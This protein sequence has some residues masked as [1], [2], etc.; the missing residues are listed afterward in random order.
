[1]TITVPA[2]ARGLRADVFLAREI[3]ASRSEIQRWMEAGRVTVSGRPLR[4]KDRV[5][6]GDRIDVEPLAP[7]T[8]RVEPDAGVP[9]DV[10]YTDDDLVVVMK[11][12]GVVVHPAPGHLQGTL[13]SGL[14]ALGLFR[15]EDLAEDGASTRPGIVH[16][17]DAGTS[18]VMVV[19]R[20][21]AAR[22][23]LRAQFSAHSIERAYEAIVVG[24]PKDGRIETLH[25]RHPKNRLLFTTHVQKGRRAVTFVRTI[26][27][28]ASAAH[29]ECGL[30]TGRTHQIRVHLAEVLRTPVLGDRVY[31]K[32]PRDPK[33]RRLGEALG[34]QALHARL[35]GFLHPTTKAPVRFEAEAPNDFQQ[36][37]RALRQG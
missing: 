31:G 14:L 12:A 13:V 4:A 16:R 9:F 32:P 28:F 10:L 7:P 8:T 3:D 29:V 27:R 33:L 6:E 2:S 34:H 30:E 18:G 22:E 36:A 15:L 37:L 35:L 11:P 21:P 20:T 24:H 1:V 5:R 26:E 17:L 25:G 19:A 23:S